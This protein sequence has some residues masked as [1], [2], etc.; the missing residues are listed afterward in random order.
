VKAAVLTHPVR[1]LDDEPTEPE[2]QPTQSDDEPRLLVSRPPNAMAAR[3]IGD[4]HGDYTSL[5]YKAMHNEPEALSK[6]DQAKMSKEATDREASEK[7]K[8]A[9]HHADQIAQAV[10]GLEVIRQ[11]IKAHHILTRPR[12]RRLQAALCELRA[13]D[14]D[15]RT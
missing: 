15:M 2:L 12:H 8:T 7:A 3:E 14:L 10:S 9:A 13:V 1:L 4:G 5:P 6:D 11:S